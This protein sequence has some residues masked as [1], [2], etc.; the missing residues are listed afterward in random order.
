[1]RR[2]IGSNIGCRMIGL[3]IGALVGILFAPK[4]GEQTRAYVK[5]KAG[6]GKDYAERQARA[7]LYRAREVMSRSKPINEREMESILEA[8]EVGR[9]KPTG[10]STGPSTGD[11]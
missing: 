9:R 2:E 1:M 8:I 7:L 10:S 3:G 6:E 4:S 5:Q 11:M